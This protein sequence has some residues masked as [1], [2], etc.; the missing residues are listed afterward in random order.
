MVLE[1][2]QLAMLA[3]QSLRPANDDKV[4]RHFCDYV[5]LFLLYSIPG[6]VT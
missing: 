6:H 3:H 5:F 2:F 1:M 4:K